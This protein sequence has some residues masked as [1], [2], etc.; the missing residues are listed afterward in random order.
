MPLGNPTNDLNLLASAK[1]QPVVPLS[2]AKARKT[3]LAVAP[4]ADVAPDDDLSI[5]TESDEDD[6]P[7][8]E[9]SDSYSSSG[10]P[11]DE[12]DTDVSDNSNVGE[13]VYVSDENDPELPLD[14]ELAMWFTTYKAIPRDA[15]TDLLQILNRRGFSLP[16]DGRT[17]LHTM[18][19]VPTIQKSGGTYLYLGIQ[20]MVQRYLP[21]CPYVATDCMNVSMKVNSDGIPLFTSSVESLWPISVIVGP[22][23]PFPVALWYGESKPNSPEEYLRDFLDEVIMLK[24]EGC[25]MGE[26]RVPFDIDVFVCDSP[27]RAYLKGIVGH[28]GYNACERCTAHGTTVSH[29]RVFGSEADIV[30]RTD[31]K[32]AAAEYMTGV[33]PHQHVASPLLELNM[34]LVTGFPLDYMHLVLEGVMK[35]VLRYWKGYFKRIRT[36]RLSSDMIKRVNERIAAINLP[37]EFNRQCRSLKHTDRWKATEYRSFLL[38]HGM[39]VTRGI[40]PSKTYKHF[41]S[42]VVAIRILCEHENNR[43]NE[44][45]PFGRE[46]LQY[47][48]GN[49]E[50]VYGPTFKVYN[51]HSLLHLVDDV[52]NFGRPLDDMSAF[53]F[54]NYLGWLKKLVKGRNKPVVQICKRLD[55]YVRFAGMKKG[56]VNQKIDLDRNR[57]F[58]IDSYVCAKSMAQD[59]DLDIEFFKDRHVGNLAAVGG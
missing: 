22:I 26:T 29:R 6:L 16:F 20:N 14:L 50:E 4:A 38:Y 48:V 36:G 3:S 9:N 51:V 24:R 2:T 8:N 59:G 28:S 19:T 18:R 49:S 13:N 53:P 7:S 34:P 25:I 35:R 52:D 56:W 43:R 45:A 44:L 40:I 37:S 54:E 55:E 1:P 39:V 58:K 30:P 41:L 12:S 57:S 17:L 27:A 10:P 33:H 31:E 23:G 15:L 11:T 32:F 42:L 21:F 47:F 5:A 46:L